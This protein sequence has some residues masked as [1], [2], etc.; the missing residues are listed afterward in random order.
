VAGEREV[1][2]SARAD[3]APP[4]RDDPA[5]RLDH[6]GLTLSEATDRCR[7]ATGAAE[8]RIQ[9]RRY[10]GRLTVHGDVGHVR[11]A[12]VSAPVLHGAH[13]I[14]VVGLGLDVDLVG[15]PIRSGPGEHKVAV[16]GHR[17]LGAE[18]RQ[19][20]PRALQTVDR[21][22]DRERG[23]RRGWRLVVVEDRH[24][25]AALLAE[26]RA[27]HVGE[28]NLEALR[29]LARQV[30]TD[31]HLH[32]PRRR[33]RVLE[34]NERA[35]GLEVNARARRAA[36]RI[37]NDASR[38]ARA[39]PARDQHQRGAARLPDRERRTAQL[40]RAG[41]RARPR[42]AARGRSWAD[43]RLLEPRHG[44]GREAPGREPR[45]RM[46]WIYDRRRRGGLA[47]AIIDRLGIHGDMHH[48][49]RPARHPVERDR[50]S[51]RLPAAVPILRRDSV[52]S[53]PASLS[54]TNCPGAQ[55]GRHAS[56]EVAAP[57]SQSCSLPNANAV[58]PTLKN[59]CPPATVYA[60]A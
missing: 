51:D 30:L 5:G 2:G 57:G 60:R 12:H 16:R 20:Q 46:L 8:R 13:L 37:H 31:R 41:V 24:R 18:V 19:H 38:A 45:P 11:A 22:A 14:R 39:A 48:E 53:R 26:L 44:T 59:T 54:T 56:G 1:G 40:H 52:P 58:P 21:A 7:N 27:P 23:R 17:H 42:R 4:G 9:T 50:Q 10:G 36:A 3:G 43:R 55:I 28:R 33:I 29:R 35:G 32:Q 15:L 47:P 49:Q 25:A 34:P 6:D